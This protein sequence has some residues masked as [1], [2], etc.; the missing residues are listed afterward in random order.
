MEKNSG[1]P[2]FIQKSNEPQVL[3][4]A[5]ADGKNKGQYKRKESMEMSVYERF[6]VADLNGNHLQRVQSLEQEL[7]QEL[8]ENIVLIAYDEEDK[9]GK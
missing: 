8:G 6:P 5:K 1:T 7:R 9:Q 2:V 3:H 4:N